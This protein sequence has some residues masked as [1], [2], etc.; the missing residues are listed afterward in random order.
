MIKHFV[1]QINNLKSV[2]NLLSRPTIIHEGNWVD[3]FLDVN[4]LILIDSIL[5]SLKLEIQ[6]NLSFISF[7]F[8]GM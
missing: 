1:I 7:S 6:L 5:I 2:L 8:P 3:G 4:G